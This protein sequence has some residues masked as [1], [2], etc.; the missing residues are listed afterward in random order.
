MSQPARTVERCLIIGAPRAEVFRALLD[1]GILSRWMYATVRWKPTRGASYRIEW[2]DSAQPAVAQGEILEIDENRKLVLSWFM[3]RDG[4]ETTASFELDDEESGKTYLKFRHAGFPGEPAWQVRYDMVALE[5]DKVLENLRFLLEEHREGASPTYLRL[6]RRVAA[7]RERAHLYWVGPA[8]I[9]S[10]LADDAFVDP[11]QGGEIDLRLKEGGR[12][13]GVIRN[14]VPGR[15][16]RVLWEE[17]G[18]R[19]LIGLSFWPDGD[20]CMMTL[21]LRSYAIGEGERDAVAAR[22]E[23]RFD[24]LQESLE[25]EPGALPP[26]G[27]GAF[28]I[29]R[30][31]EAPPDR[32]WRAW[33]DPVS[34]V[35]WFCDRA[36]FTLQ[37]GHA[38][39]LLWTGYG[40]QRGVILD[41]E[42]GVRLRFSWDLPG[43][44]ATTEASISLAPVAGAREKTRLVLSHSGWGE[45]NR[46][47]AER[48]GHLCGWR[49]ML[50]ALDFFLRSGGQGPRRTFLLRRRFALGVSEL[51]DRFL[52]R[53]GLAGWLGDDVTFEPKEGGALQARPRGGEVLRGVVTMAE[54]DDGL[55]IETR[56]PEPAYIEFFWG[57]DEK[58]SWLLASGFAYGVPEAWPLRQRI[59]WSER[60]APLAGG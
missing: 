23:A 44:R 48:R 5:W 37:R 17:G 33:T 31:V 22:W 9:R 6:Q 42:P 27:E 43:L 46:W 21:T 30:I 54:S 14:I 53:D 15:H 58:E 1:P 45:G 49:S 2:Q 60:L 52:T 26:G 29:E 39:S 47:E 3:E 4:C 19:S 25:R 56:E 16:M 50:G 13:T 51:S 11:A 40:D 24:R 10:W 18:K 35:S 41:V 38:F 34:L 8:A 32:V 57:G 20:G 12:V 55:A 28:E 59:L 36:E 7:T